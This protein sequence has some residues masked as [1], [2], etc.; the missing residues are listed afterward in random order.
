MLDYIEQEC[1]ADIL[2]K[3]LEV[4]A[5]L[6]SLS[7][8]T[9]KDMYNAANKNIIDPYI[10]LRLPYLSNKDNIKG[11]NSTLSNEEIEHWKKVMKERKEQFK[12]EG[13]I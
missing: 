8:H 11:G 2:A 1:I 12:R 4:E 10:R 7:P 9:A 6:V 3:R 5:A 13:K